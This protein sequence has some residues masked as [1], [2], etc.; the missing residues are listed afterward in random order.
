MTVNL[1]DFTQGNFL[2]KEDVPHPRIIQIAAILAPEPKINPDK[3]ILAIVG[4]D[5]RLLLNKTNMRML[6]S[7]FSTGDGGAMV[8]RQVELYV[9]PYVPNPSNPASPGG[10]RIRAA[11]TL[12]TS[13]TGALPPATV[14]TAAAAA[15]QAPPPVQ[16]QPEPHAAPA[17]EFNDDI[18]W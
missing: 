7:I 12:A 1:D 16:Q 13:A 14:A 11:A 8:G 2:K 15:V 9:D 10:L 3:P 17:P 5:K 18:P 4:T 6:R